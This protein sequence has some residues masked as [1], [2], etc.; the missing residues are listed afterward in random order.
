[1]NS[2]LGHSSCSQPGF[3][4]GRAAGE[5]GTGRGPRFPPVWGSGIGLFSFPLHLGS[6]E[7]PIPA[8]FPAPSSGGAASPQRA[9]TGRGGGHIG[10]P[11]WHGG[12]AGTALNPKPIR[13]WEQYPQS[14]ALQHLHPT[15]KAPLRSGT[16]VALSAP[17][18][19]LEVGLREQPEFV[20]SI[21]MDGRMNPH[22][23]SA[24]EAGIGDRG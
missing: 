18:E 23:K 8:P 12:R 10:I 9:V 5:E 20:E 4:Q 19:R 21:L 15:D 24:L 6:S 14:G 17:E 2:P 22:P 13:E 3:S 7:S 1:M 16:D 11:G